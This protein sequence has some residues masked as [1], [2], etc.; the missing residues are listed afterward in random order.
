MMSMY[1]AYVVLLYTPSDAIP[2][3]VR[4]ELFQHALAADVKLGCAHDVR[5]LNPLE[6]A[7]TFGVIREFMRRTCK[8]LGSEQPVSAVICSTVPSLSPAPVP[9]IRRLSH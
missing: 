6:V 7:Q 9:S 8:H 3:T 2:R 5:D 1:A 4:T